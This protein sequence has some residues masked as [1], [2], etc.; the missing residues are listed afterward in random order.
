[1]LAKIETKIKDCFLIENGSFKDIRGYFSKCFDKKFLIENYLDFNPQECFY[2]VS[3]KDVIRGMHFQ[4]PP[5]D[6]SKL[7]TVLAGSI[8]DVILDLRPWSQTYLEYVQFRIDSQQHVSV[9]VPK[10]CAHGFKSL[11]DGT[12]TMYHVSEGYDPNLDKG[13]RYDSFGY[14]WSTSN[15]IIS[16]R[17]LSF[18]DIQSFLRH[19]NPF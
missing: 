8:D 14:D 10:G 16:R 2:S 18:D 11:E 7:V 3:H 6:Q 1:M 4:I 19:P 13:L 9:F 15:P 5:K 12:V 17:D